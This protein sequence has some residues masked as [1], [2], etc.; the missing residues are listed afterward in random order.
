MAEGAEGE[1]GLA[2]LGFVGEDDFEDGDVLDHRSGNGSDQE[3]DGGNEEE[4][5][6]DPGD[7]R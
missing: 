4:D 1:G 6:S 3:Q 5:H 7:L 2:D